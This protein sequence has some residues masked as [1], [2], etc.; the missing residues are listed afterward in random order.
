MKA[1]AV[2][3]AAVFAAAT[4][5]PA[6]LPAEARVR[7]GDDNGLFR[8]DDVSVEL[9][10]GSFVFTDEE[11][12]E[13]VEINARAELIVN[14]RTVKLSRAQRALVEDY[15]ETLDA[16][17]EDAKSIGL[18]G[19]KVGVKGAA[20]GLKAAVGVLRL[21]SPDYDGD[22]LE[23][24]LREDEEKLERSASKLERRAERLEKLADK[25]ERLHADLRDN[26]HELNELGWF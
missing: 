4:F 10:D 26:V 21:L 5:V 9:E 1:S 7:C 25:L 23:E 13:T 15:Y 19:A 2:I 6:G 14:G 11:T 20:I 16:I 3:L 12:E 8:G 18:Q 24:D 17:I 22:D